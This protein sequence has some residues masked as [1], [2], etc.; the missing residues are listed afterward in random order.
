MCA[1][2]RGTPSADVLYT[3]CGGC[4]TPRENPLLGKLQRQ[5]FLS[6]IGVGYRALCQQ[7]N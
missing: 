7:G 3:I 6:K 4:L 2:W 1:A 5:A